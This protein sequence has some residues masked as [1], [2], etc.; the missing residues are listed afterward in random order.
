MRDIKF[1]ELD[2]YSYWITSFDLE[3]D[4]NRNDFTKDYFSEDYKKI[5]IKL[6]LQRLKDWEINSIFM[7]NWL[8]ED[9]PLWTKCAFL[10]TIQ[11]Y[12]DWWT[13]ENYIWITEE[14]EKFL[15]CK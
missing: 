12:Y 4:Y 15:N 14:W 1:E 2:D 3:P 11:K 5:D 10:N 6:F 13:S 7:D 9:I 8:Y